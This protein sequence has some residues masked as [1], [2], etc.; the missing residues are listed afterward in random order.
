MFRCNSHSQTKQSANYVYCY[1][2]EKQ[3]E[4]EH[5]KIGENVRKKQP[6]K[7]TMN[8]DAVFSR[9]YLHW[10]MLNADQNSS[11]TAKK[12]RI[13]GHWSCFCSQHFVD[14]FCVAC[15]T[16]VSIMPLM[17][18]EILEKLCRSTSFASRFYAH[19]ASFNSN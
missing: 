3:S 8:L 9:I 2:N 6:Q 17:D 1:K 11:E 12:C 14:F 7:M 15:H 13:R 5:L 16:N 18:G 10:T 4:S 19:F